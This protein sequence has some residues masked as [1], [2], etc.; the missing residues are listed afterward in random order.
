MNNLM[1]LHPQINVKGTMATCQAFL[2]TKPTPNATIIGISAGVVSLSA[3]HLVRSSAYTSSKM[4][5]VKLLE[6]LAAENPDVHVVSLH[7]GVVETAMYAKSGM[8]AET[9]DGVYISLPFLFK[10]TT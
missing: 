4:A 7:P 2:A 6:I 5:A 9:Y 10:R 8:K 3:A 1:F